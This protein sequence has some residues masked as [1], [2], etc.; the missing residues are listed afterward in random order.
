MRNGFQAFYLPVKITFLALLF[1]HPSPMFAQPYRQT[2]AKIVHVAV[3]GKAAL[4]LK[5]F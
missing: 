5:P 3:I 1:P 4:G 2:I